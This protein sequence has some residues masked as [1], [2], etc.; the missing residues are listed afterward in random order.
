MKVTRTYTIDIKNVEKLAKE[1]NASAL[2]NSLLEK[3]YSKAKLV[4]LGKEK[5]DMLTNMAQQRDELNNQ[6][7]AIVNAPNN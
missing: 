7:E 1:D 2:I 6:I 4:A 5:L 3:H